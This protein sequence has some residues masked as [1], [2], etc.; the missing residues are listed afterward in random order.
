MCN[1][2]A[3]YGTLRY[4][5]ASNGLMKGA[6]RIGLDRIPAR[7][8]TLG[9]YPGI[10]M[11]ATASTVVDV[12]EIPNDDEFLRE[13]DRY[14]GFTKGAPEQSLFARKKTLLTES[15]DEVY[16]YEYCY[17]VHKDNEITS[18]DWFDVYDK[19]A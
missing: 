1:K 14:E 18:G 12:Y 17:D 5:A 13:I 6:K 9:W 2:I 16:I 3:V 19:G 10:K 8:Y 7:L 15:N 11:D 4:G